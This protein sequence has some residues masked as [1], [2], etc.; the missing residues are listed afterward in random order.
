LRIILSS[1]L[2]AGGAH[3]DQHVTVADLGLW[4]IRAAES[5]LAVVLDD[6]CLHDGSPRRVIASLSEVEEGRQRIGRGADEMRRPIPAG[7]V[8]GGAG[9]LIGTRGPA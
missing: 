6:E 7:G 5:V 9:A 3:L 1:G 4:Y 2:I 8:Y